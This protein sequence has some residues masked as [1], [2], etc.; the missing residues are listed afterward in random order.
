MTSPSPVVIL[1]HPIVHK[2]SYLI[3]FLN[4]SGIG[5]WMESA[6]GAAGKAEDGVNSIRIR[7]SP[8]QQRGLPWI[9]YTTRMCNQAWR[10]TH[11]G[12][13]SLSVLPVGFLS[14]CPSELHAFQYPV[15]IHGP[16]FPIAPWPSSAGSGLISFT[17][18][19]VCLYP[20]GCFH[21]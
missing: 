5:G 21:M 10:L 11:Q 15:C 19:P 9:P 6:A 7:L 8:S 2:V 3:S 14:P 16:A 17:Y 1:T 18:S 13:T 12:G 20:L 4:H